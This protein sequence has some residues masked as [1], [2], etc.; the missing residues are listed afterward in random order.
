MTSKVDSQQ[1]FYLKGIYPVEIVSDAKD[2]LVEI[3]A[4]TTFLHVSNYMGGQNHARVGMTKKRWVKSGEILKVPVRFVW[5]SRRR[6]AK[7][8]L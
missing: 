2:G 5:P 4:K 7:G 6:M 8:H 1:E 3:R